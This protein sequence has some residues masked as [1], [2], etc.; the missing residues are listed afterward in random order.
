MK[1]LSL[2][3]WKGIII[4]TVVFVFFTTYG[5]FDKRVDN[6][7]NDNYSE[8]NW[9]LDITPIVFDWY[10]DFS[11]FQTKWGI[12]P[13]SK[14]V[15]DKTGVSLNLITPSGDETE[16]LNSMI[17]TGKLPDFITLSAQSDG[18]KNIIQNGLALPL[19]KLSEQYDAYFM[20]VADK[21]KLEWY[22]EGDGHIYCYPN[23]SSP[24]TDFN[25]FK[26]EKPS[27]QAFLVR[28]DI[29]EALGK[30]DMRTPEGFLNALERAKKEFHMSDGQELIPLGLHEFNESGNLSLDSILPNF[31]AVPREENGMVYDKDTD[32]EYIR[33]LKTLRMANEKGLLSKEIFVDKRAQI[34]EKITEGR[35]FAM[36]YQSSDMSAQQLELYSRDKNKA[37]IAIDGPSNS[38]LD[39]P[40][41]AG[42]SISGWTVT[43]ISKSC[44][45]PMRAMRFLSYLISEEGNKDLYLGIKGSTWDVINGKEQFKPEVVDLLNKDRIAF[46]NKY[47]AASTYWMLEDGDLV[48]KWTPDNEEAIKMIS[49]WARGKTYNYS[50]FDNVYTYD[51]SEE[52]V[53]FSRISTK[54][55]ST[56]K[57]L[58]IAKNEEEFNSILNEFIIYRKEQGW[59]KLQKYAQQ[60]YEEN[61]KKLNV[62]R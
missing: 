32:N 57:K 33:W 61:K 8:E 37:Y 54:W 46:D 55:G 12:N 29:Y 17:E 11:W 25:N 36:L 30:P 42:D 52:G 3:V 41:L 4:L 56:L 23:F 19:D 60:K 49:D 18:Y 27:N 24:V 51:D 59:D 6:K 20:K 31:L 21:Q 35:Y 34:E 26:E 62:L 44:K 22:R 14:Y 15:T 2:K 28:K 13:V 53:A 40:K 48:Q 39:P 1:M 47:G 50:L 45:D 43:L 5:L 58:L 9:K 7:V 16:K 10:I 38:K